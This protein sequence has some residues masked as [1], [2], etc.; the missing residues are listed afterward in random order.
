MATDA[1]TTPA[2]STAA[3][4]TDTQQ[5]TPANQPTTQPEGGQP[6]EGDKG[7]QP[8]FVTIDG[9]QIPTDLN[10]VEDPDLR[11]YYQSMLD[12]HKEGEQPAGGDGGDQQS[13][14]QPP[15]DGKKDG[16]QPQGGEPAGKPAQVPPGYVP[17]AVAQ[18]ERNKR[19][20]LEQQVAFLNGQLEVFK[21]RGATTP[22]ATPTG[23]QPGAQPQQPTHDEQIKAH[24]AAITALAA[25]FDGGEITFAEY[26]AK[27]GELQ[28][29]IDEIKAEQWAARIK[30]AAPQQTVSATD[31]AEDVL[32]TLEKEKVA[33]Q[34]ETK[35]PYSAVIFPAKM[36]A[37]AN[38]RA[39]LERRQNTL[40]EEARAAVIAE[41]PGIQ[42]GRQ[43]EILFLNKLAALSDQYGPIW[44]PNHKPAQ[45]QAPAG[46]GAKPGA[47]PQ[48]SQRAQDRFSKLALQTQQPPDVTNA[49]RSGGDLA[50]TDDAIARM[51]D[52]E[53]AKLP[54]EVRNR[55][56]GTS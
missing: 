50:I 2:D 15:A 24:R 26:E 9:Q 46:G 29:K 14:Q 34:L 56:L 25:K 39:L 10:K 30:P 28:D 6:T 5:Q 22:A 52:D 48:P 16:A 17:V 23:G 8:E 54:Q 36:P 41:N 53:F 1:T 33:E 44:F 27:R 20:T 51:S 45:T 4:P 43:A 35:H 11:A 38:E 49:G 40:A 18:E 13:Q 31:V 12:A 55:Y 3:Q 19:Q 21:T 32:T 37:D 47:T 7:N 42:A